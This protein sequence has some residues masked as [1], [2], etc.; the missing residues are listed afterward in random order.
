MSHSDMEGPGKWKRQMRS[1]CGGNS[2]AN[3]EEG[4]GDGGLHNGMFA[5]D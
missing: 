3:G 4:P 5:R 2:G 1:D